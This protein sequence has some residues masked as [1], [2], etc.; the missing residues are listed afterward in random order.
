L[1][2]N[3][4]RIEARGRHEIKKKTKLPWDSRKF[5]TLGDRPAQTKPKT[6]GSLR[7]VNACTNSKKKL[8]KKV[9]TE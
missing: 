8:L 4:A 2:K 1:Q 7:G 6:G 3:I 5:V 9:S